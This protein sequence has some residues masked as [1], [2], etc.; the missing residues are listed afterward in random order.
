MTSAF[1][2]RSRVLLATAGFSAAALVLAGCS[3]GSGDPLAED[4]AS[5][6]GSIVVGTTDKVL[7]LDPA[8]SYDNGSFAVQNQVY[9]FL[10]NS[11]YG[12]PDVEPDLAVS[13]EYTSPND[14]TVT[15]KPDLKFAN[16]HALTASDVKFTFDRI[17]TIAANGADNGN[18]PSSLLANVESVAAPDDTTV[19]F[20]LKT[21]N[22]QTFEQVLSSPAGPIVDEE[23]FPADA[24][25]DPAAIVAANAFAGQYVITEFQLNQLVAYAP[26]ADYQ[27]VLP[28]PA[29]GG[30]TARYYAD[31]TTMKLAVQN[32]EIDVAGRSLGATDIAD[33][34]K[35]DSV[36]VVE[37]PGGEI[38][39][40]TFNL[41]TQPFGKT[42]GEADEAKALAVRQA[43]ADLVD[44][45]EL[46]TQ[47]YN[48]TYTPLY[49]YVADGLSGANEALKGIY[50]DG[51][52][53]PDADKAAKVL[54]D[55]GVQTPVA[56]QLQFNPDH[57]G[58]GSD[59]EY[60]LIKQQLE[61]TGLFQVNLQS[62]IWDQYSKA[63]VNDEYPAYQLGWFPDY[64]DADNYL[65]P[66]FS[67]QSFVKNH[68]DNPTVTDLITQQLSEADSTKRAEIIGQIQDDVAADLP[69]LPLL[70]GSQVAVA[71]KDVKGV[72]LD[73]SFK[74]RY[75]PITKG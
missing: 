11:P 45:D 25:A 65:T 53:G 41:N 17:A 29:N 74:F 27:G 48:G 34:K 40:I 31:E 73:A 21:A 26:N 12:S 2:R 15:L 54:S 33:L 75:A 28:K 70:Q 16:G 61:A 50:G 7:S 57:Y 23:V 52:G 58:A 64:S 56:L 4:G 5:G 35:D 66:F 69:T 63:R 13:G 59:D 55:A 20:T 22:D 30:V 10:F 14:F 43:A 46:S 42:T 9:P 6:G 32:G 72:T 51:N 3:G 47:V 67:P 62:T 24:L 71:G 36:Q 39:Y 68:Y 49:S 38:R 37:G 8:G 18:G 19:V 44:R 1:P 60:A